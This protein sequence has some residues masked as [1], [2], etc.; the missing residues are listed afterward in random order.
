MRRAHITGVAQAA[1]VVA[2]A[3]GATAASSL[4]IL[5]PACVL[6]TGSTGG[7]VVE[8]GAASPSC[9]TG[10]VGTGGVGSGAGAEAGGGADAG[11]S[12]L[13]L[14]CISAVD[15]GDAGLG[16]C[17]VSTGSAVVTMCNAL[18]CPGPLPVQACQTPAE[19]GGG[20]VTCRRQKCTFAA[21]SVEVSL[22]GT[23]PFVCTPE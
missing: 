19:C 21:G 10:N 8:A 6:V 12:G 22:C 1:T 11:C 3:A 2:G 18:P 5:L 9:A 15:C 4:A 13:A 17:V 7:Y 20:S 23:V 16:C 14:N